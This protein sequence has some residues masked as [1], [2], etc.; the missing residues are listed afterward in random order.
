[1]ESVP[2]HLVPRNAA[3]TDPSRVLRGSSEAVEGGDL[4]LV[5]VY[6]IWILHLW[7]LDLNL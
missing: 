5:L 1:M 4:P 2:R 7:D 6:R 3:E